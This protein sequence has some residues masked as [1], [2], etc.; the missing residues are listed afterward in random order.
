[1]SVYLAK[2]IFFLDLRHDVN[3]ENF[4]FSLIYM[5]N[6]I[7][8]KIPNFRD[9]EFYFLSRLFSERIILVSRY[10]SGKFSTKI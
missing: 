4:L 3:P 10:I 6:K 5:A 7:Q 9:Y 2:E 1:M 8:E